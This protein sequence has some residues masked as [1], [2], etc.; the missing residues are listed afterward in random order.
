MRS[1]RL[2]NPKATI[3]SCGL[4]LRGFPLC[5]WLANA[6]MPACLATSISLRTRSPESFP[7]GGDSTVGGLLPDAG[8]LLTCLS[9]NSLEAQ[10]RS[11]STSPVSFSP[12]GPPSLYVSATDIVPGI[13]EDG[14]KDFWVILTV[15]DEDALR[16]LSYIILP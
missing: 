15:V 6:I 16:S 8:F 7:W 10:A 9:Q 2:S 12:I 1:R 13:H 5:R 3:D 14:Q 4:V 11:V